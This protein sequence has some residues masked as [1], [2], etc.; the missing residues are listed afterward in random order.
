[1]KQNFS[2]LRSQGTAVTFSPHPTFFESLIL[3]ATSFPGHSALVWVAGGLSHMGYS[4]SL[5]C[6]VNHWFYQTTSPPP[7]PPRP[8]QDCSWLLC[9]WIS[10]LTLHP[11]H[12]LIEI[13]TTALVSFPPKTPL[14][15]YCCYQSNLSSCQYPL[16]VILENSS[17]SWNGPEI[18]IP[19][20]PLSHICNPFISYLLSGTSSPTWIQFSSYCFW[21]A[22]SLFVT[23]SA[24]GRLLSLVILKLNQDKIGIFYRVCINE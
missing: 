15:R 20:S 10:F 19:V 16:V 4:I 18:I 12:I 14:T 3:Q 13:E 5:C 9:L 17:I 24:L 6:S 7:P 21:N 11:I 1:M 2:V 8:F 22:F 23:F